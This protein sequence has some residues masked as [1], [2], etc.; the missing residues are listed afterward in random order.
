MSA[1]HPKS[2]WEDKRR[3]RFSASVPRILSEPHL[4]SVK[5]SHTRTHYVLQ[6]EHTFYVYSIPH[7]TLRLTISPPTGKFY[8]HFD[9][10]H[11]NLLAVTYSDGTVHVWDLLELRLVFR[12]QDPTLASEFRPRWLHVH[13]VNPV[14]V[15]SEDGYPSRHE[16]WPQV[17]TLMVQDPS[18]DGDIFWIWQLSANPPKQAK[19]PDGDSPSK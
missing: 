4:P 17:P 19:N 14:I 5:S 15:E 7:L 13:F 3:K 10:N 1:P 6:L 12:I 9:L 18:L 8:S 16:L 11:D 2:R